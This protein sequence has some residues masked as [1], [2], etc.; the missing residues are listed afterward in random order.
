MAVYVDNILKIARAEVGY[1]ESP[2]K[3]N[4]TKYGIAYGWNGVPWCVIFVWWCFKQAGADD[5]LPIKTAS[6]WQ[7]MDAAKKAGIWVT[8]DFKPG[9]ILIYNFPGG[10]TTDHTGIC[11]SVT[12]KSVV[13]IEGNTGSG[14]DANGGA[15]M[16]RMRDISLIYGAVRPEYDVTR[17]ENPATDVT[18]GVIRTGGQPQVGD[19]VYF[20]GDRQYVNS[21]Q[22]AASVRGKPCDAKITL[23]RLN[24][25][26]PYHLN[27]SGVCGW[28]NAKDVFFP[29]KAKVTASSLNIRSGAKLGD[30]KTGALENGAICVIVEERKS[31]TDG[32]IWGRLA[33]G[34]GWIAVKYIM[35]I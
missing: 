29:Y 22:D 11:E 16:R 33:D 1:K 19:S 15:V 27:G 35:K 9:D 10:A 17:S 21:Y 20:T 13:A 6:C 14:N 28:V 3:S 12:A 2:A 23:L 18:A 24:N 25:A 5:L 7:L 26:H 30:N 34:R 8:K 32:Y 4:K 31:A